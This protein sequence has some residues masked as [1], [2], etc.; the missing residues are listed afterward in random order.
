MTNFDPLFFVFKFRKYCVLIYPAP[1]SQDG[2][3]VL[4]FITSTNAN[5]SSLDSMRFKVCIRFLA[6]ATVYHTFSPFMLLNIIQNDF[7]FL[8]KSGGFCARSCCAEIRL[9]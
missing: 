1:I 8:E 9:T 3:H 5:K 4:H 2:R 7:L 6:I